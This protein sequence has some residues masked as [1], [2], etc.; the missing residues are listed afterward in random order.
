MR[1][2]YTKKRFKSII[3]FENKKT[4]K[5]LNLMNSITQDTRYLPHEIKTRIYAVET[6]R[7][8][9]SVKYVC[10]KYH[11]SK[12]SLMRW[13]KRYDGSKESLIDKSHRPNTTHPN[14]HTEEELKW[15]WNYIRR[16][17]SITLSELWVKLKDNKGYKR[18]PGSLYRVL[19]RNGYKYKIVIHHTSKYI[20]KHYET[21]NYL[22]EKWQ[23]DV[24]YV[25]SKCI[26]NAIPSDTKFYQYTCLDEAS[27]Q[28]FLYWYDE[29]SPYATCDFINRCIKFYGYKPREIQTDNGQ[30]FTWNKENIKVIHPMDNLCQ[31]L[32]IIHHKIRP[33]TPRHN[34]KG[35]RS[36]RSD[37][38][39]FYSYHSFYS[40]SDLQ[41]Q[42]AIYLKRSNN[43]PM[44]TL[45]YLSPNQ[46]RETLSFC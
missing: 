19:R 37:N 9:N 1:P 14:S 16:N 20:P 12:A 39:R 28:R 30:E 29:L 21:P 2:I 46:K 42:G 7:K 8:G 25:P 36:H 38:E 33:R 26:T 10:R 27:R 22:G 41:T 44:Q 31:K 3:S 11:I 24:K 17:P 32:D 23:I 5:D 4:R 34:G 45:G 15:I 43:I 35:E 6:Y 13:N 40:L 18:H